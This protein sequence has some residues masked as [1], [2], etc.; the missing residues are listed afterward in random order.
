MAAFFGERQ[1]IGNDVADLLLRQSLVIIVRH[2]VGISLDK[3][4]TRIQGRF[5]EVL[6]GGERR[7]P[8]GREVGNT[9]E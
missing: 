5:I 1:E 6:L 7:A 8:F 3:V 9:I 2:G 4:D